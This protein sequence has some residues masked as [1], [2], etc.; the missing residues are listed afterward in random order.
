MK[1]I[2]SFL[3]FLSLWL[4]SCN[5]SDT[6]PVINGW[7]EVKNSPANTLGYRHDDIFFVNKNTGWLV[8]TNGEAYHTTN[9]GASW[10][11]INKTSN[12]FFRCV[13]FANE[14]KGWIG[15]FNLFNS[16]VPYK[17]LFE[18]ND[19]GKSWANVSKRIIGPSADGLCGMQVINESTIYGVGR[20]CGPP[21]FIKSLDGGATWASKDLSALASGLVD[22][23][24]FNAMEGFIVGE[25]EGGKTAVQQRNAKSAILFTADGGTTWTRKYMNT[26]PGNRAWKIHFPSRN[27][28]YVSTEG[29]DAEGVIL[30]TTNGGEEW[31]K[32][33]VDPGV[34]FEGIAFIDANKGWVASAES[35]YMTE[36]GGETWK[37]L[38]FGKNINRIRVI[39]SGLVFACG[40]KVYKWSSK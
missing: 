28:G 21:V 23:F 36:N 5:K 15:N 39:N 8:N 40:E 6:E 20:W 27:V 25:V 35:V 19:G 30:K 38:N 31:E 17:A 14:S 2:K 13:G 22:I 11:L 18:T 34:S 16:P 4:Y 9:G 33:M 24:F 29:E 3:I 10:E 12:V 26:M 37:N 7:A 32:V 1:G